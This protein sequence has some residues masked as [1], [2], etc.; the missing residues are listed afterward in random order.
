MQQI[1]QTHRRILIN[2]IIGNKNNTF[3]NKSNLL[4]NILLTKLLNT[5]IV[6]YLHP[7]K[8]AMA[9]FS[10]SE[11]ALRLRKQ[12]KVHV[13]VSAEVEKLILQLAKKYKIK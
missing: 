12:L 11:N 9:T 13:S 4:I 1:R 6:I 10:I 7:M 2:V 8:T 5:K 3:F